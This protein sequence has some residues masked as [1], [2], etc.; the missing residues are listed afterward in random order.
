MHFLL[1]RDAESSVV[2]NTRVRFYWFT[3]LIFCLPEFI[4]LP[5]LGL[6]L[7]FR[8]MLFQLWCALA[9]PGWFV[10][11]CKGTC[12]SDLNRWLHANQMNILIRWILILKIPNQGAFSKVFVVLKKIVPAIS[13]FS[14]RVKCEVV[15]CLNLVHSKIGYKWVRNGRL[16]SLP[17]SLPLE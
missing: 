17:S 7:W 11:S 9:S 8:T 4:V 3:A 13:P 15:V 16:G 5:A 2:W 6:G 10:S 1:L 12:A 14:K